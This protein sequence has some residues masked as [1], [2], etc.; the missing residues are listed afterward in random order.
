MLN[1]DKFNNSESSTT[2][3]NHLTTTTDKD[4]AE[5]L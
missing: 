4:Y 3:T 2:K 5:P 1:F